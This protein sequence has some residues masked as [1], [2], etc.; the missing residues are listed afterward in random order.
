[1]RRIG[2]T[3]QPAETFDYNGHKITGLGLPKPVLH[4]LYH[5]NAVKWF[6]GVLAEPA[7]V[8]PQL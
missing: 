7:K 2:S 1:M 5:D 6:P 4:K 8:G 3:S